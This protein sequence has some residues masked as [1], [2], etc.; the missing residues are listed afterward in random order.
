MFDHYITVKDIRVDAAMG[1]T[2]TSMIDFCRTDEQGI[3]DIFITDLDGSLK[4]STVVPTVT[5]ASTLISLQPNMLQFINDKTKC[6][7]VPEK[8]YSYCRDTCFRGIVYEVDPS[9][10]TSF[11]LKLCQVSNPNTCIIVP[12]Y[13]NTPDPY[14]AGR[15][16]IF[17]ANLPIGQYNAIF[18]DQN[19]QVSWPTFVRQSVPDV[20]CPI[21]GTHTITMFEPTVSYSQCTE[22][23][24]NGNV[25]ASNSEPL[26]WLR[27]LGDLQLV[28]GAGV[29]FSNALA[30][31]YTDEP[32][33]F[34][35]Y[36]DTRCLKLMRNA[37]YN[38][39]ANIKLQRKDG[40]TYI[41]N[42]NQEKCPVIV[43]FGEK[44]IDDYEYDESKSLMVNSKY[45]NVAEVSATSA[46]NSN[47]FQIIQGQIRITDQLLQKQDIRI[48]IQSFSNRL[49]VDNISMRLANETVPPPPPTCFSSSNFVE[50]KDVG[51]IRIN[52]VK[53]GDYIRAGNGK[54]YTQVYGY[55]HYDNNLESEFI[56]VSFTVDNNSILEIS[57]SHILFVQR[58][59]NKMKRSIMI[60]ASDIMVDDIL[61]TQTIRSIQR[62]QR[63]GVYAPLTYSGDFMINGI[64]VSNYVKLFDNK[65]NM[66]HHALGH[67][68]FL[69]QRLFCTFFMHVCQKETYI[70]GYG[71]LAWIIIHLGRIM[72]DYGGW[73]VNM[74]VYCLTAWFII[75]VEMV[76]KNATFMLIGILVGVIVVTSHYRVTILGRIYQ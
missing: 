1:G 47:G 20:S 33:A 42:P 35:Q 41:C 32:T 48:F 28:R 63:R 2:T 76:T 34:V 14:I 60:A 49:I 51:Y 73:F 26:Y 38:V 15:T 64:R 62:V 52:Q 6:T 17:P 37:V 11:T 8:C 74:L 40:T 59:V 30:G 55:G 23:I 53:I 45:D 57:P 65:F 43:I 9:F 12:G 18:L 5:S 29:G 31:N 10:T 66:D 69:P 75:L 50:V 7:N 46:L 21:V 16:R 67:A 36:L 39:S 72:N 58:T 19:G 68:C 24:R 22:L 13:R 25:E 54:D 70:N 44:V 71:R 61:N 3:D 27:D 56:Q 4:P